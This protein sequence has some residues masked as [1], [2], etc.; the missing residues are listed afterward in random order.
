[1]REKTCVTD[2]NL[3][4]YNVYEGLKRSILTSII[5]NHIT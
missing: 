1:M 2:D 5:I 4:T 3:F